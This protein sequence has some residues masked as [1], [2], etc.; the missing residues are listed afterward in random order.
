MLISG[1]YI[2]LY[3]PIFVLFDSIRRSRR[4]RTRIYY[5]FIYTLTTYHNK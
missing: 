1:R 2:L 5:Y 3:I 4:S